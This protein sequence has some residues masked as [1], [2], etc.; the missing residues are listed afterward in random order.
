MKSVNWCHRSVNPTLVL[1]NDK[2]L[3]HLN[4][5]VTSQNSRHWSVAN[6]TLC[7]KVPLHDIMFGVWCATGTTRIIWPFYYCS[8]T[9]TLHTSWQLFLYTHLINTRE[10]MPFPSSSIYL[11][12][13]SC[14]S[15]PRLLEPKRHSFLFNHW[16]ASIF[17]V[18]MAARTP[19]IHVFLGR[20]LFLLSFKHKH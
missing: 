10:F 2:A 18:F 5:H 15:Y 6:P 20:P 8:H 9:N 19:S 1:F 12:F 14:D 11:S 16:S 7:H 13:R 4:K 3:Y 17:L